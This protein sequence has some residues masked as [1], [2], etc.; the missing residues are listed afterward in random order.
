MAE[1]TTIAAMAAKVS[2]EIFEVFGWERVLPSDQNWACVDPDHQKETHP[3]DVVFRY[4][5]PYRAVTV[6]LTTD[7]KSFAKASVTK[8]QIGKALR[9]LV[10]STTCAAISQEWQDLYAAPD[11]TLEVAGLLFVYNH[12]GEYG[13]DFQR[14]LIES[15]ATRTG[16]PTSTVLHVI[17]PNRVSYLATV[18]NDIL[19]LRGAG[20]LPP[21]GERF[22]FFYP[23][24]IGEHARVD[25]AKAAT[26][27]TLCGPLI[28]C[29]YIN[30]AT[31]GAI[32]YYARAGKDPDEF[33][34]LL[35]YLFRYQLISNC[36][37]VRIRLASA[38]DN[39]SAVFQRA[40]TAY[41]ADFNDLPE[42]RSRLAR[43]RLEMV[44]NI[45]KVFSEVSLGMERI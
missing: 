3:S 28:V 29:R 6:H 5:H 15:D 24:L 36:D 8:Q 42:V 39:A 14:L 31:S 25:Q 9:S 26:I 35:D 21:M 19:R 2:D 37:E 7:L 16:M 43:V 4:R 10:M 45:V 40:V 23:D 41:V 33:K 32:V 44:T 17:G 11:S 18:A 38:S 12:D 22:W 34:Y 13:G 20:K 1:T 27:E 30:A